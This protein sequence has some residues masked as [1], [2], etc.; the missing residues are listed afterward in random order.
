MSMRFLRSSSLAL[1]LLGAVLLVSPAARALEIEVVGSGSVNM[2]V[3]SPADV[4]TKATAAAKK[5]AVALAVDKVL[6]PDAS[7][8]PKIAPKLDSLVTQIPDAAIVDTKSARVGDDY[9]VT[10]TLEIE[11]KKFRTL[12]SDL[13]MATN[14]AATR[15][16]S[17]LAV[18]DEFITSPRDVKAPLEELVQ[19]RHESGSTMSDKSTADAQSD[20]FD[21]TSVKSSDAVAGQRADRNGGAR[22]AAASSHEGTSVSAASSSASLKNDVQAETHDDTFY[23][24]LIKYQ[25]QGNPEKTSQTYNALM[26]Q[27]QDY[28]V[29]VIDNDLFRSKYFKEKPITIEQLQN[30][31]E[32]SKYVAFARDDAHADFFMVGTSIL[33]D[34]GKNKST[35]EANCSGVVTVKTYSTLDGESIASETTS[36]VGAGIDLS[37][38]AGNVAK[39]LAKISGAALNLRFKDFWKRRSTYG[40]EYQVSLLTAQSLPLM[41]R[42]AFSKAVAAVPGVQSST[43]RASSEKQV[44]LVVSYKGS[45]PLDQAIATGLM[46]NAAFSTL[47]ARADG[48]HMVFCMGPC[49]EAE[50]K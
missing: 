7:L 40:R 8:D 22:V 23:S 47:D 14:T 28:D 33:I 34:S 13:G 38:C 21:G 18:M 19:F 16:Y 10:V 30:S 5:K 26:G 45:E 11:D 50:A 20:S 4:R 41:L 48:N 15:A 44:Q 39:K 35:G 27:L 2:K 12:L 49:S 1:G 43:Q 31:E 24:K 37:A 17:V 9:Q 6:G 46:S 29:R 3:G 32:L 25:P 36:E 42:M